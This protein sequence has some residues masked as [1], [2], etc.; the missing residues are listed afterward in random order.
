M[1]IRAYHEGDRDAVR[2]CIVLL[3][4]HERQLDV[5]M[6]RGE[7]IADAYLQ[8]ILDGCANWNGTLFVAEEEDSILGF[9]CVWAKYRSGELDDGPKEYALVSDLVVVPGA[10]GRGLGR[11][12][13][14]RGEAFAREAD[15]EWLRV[16]VMSINAVARTLYST[17]GFRPW[18]EYME[19]PL[20]DERAGDSPAHGPADVSAR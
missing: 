11:A 10:R 17:A 2:A 20:L 13:L 3:Q 5:R 19:K 14:E 4:D 8:H 15:A 1:H 12:L 7:E 9:V 16:G 6:P 18:L